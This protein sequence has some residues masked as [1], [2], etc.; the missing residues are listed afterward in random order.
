[1]LPVVLLTV[2]TVVSDEFQVTAL[3]TSSVP[4]PEKVPVAVNCFDPVPKENDT[5]PA[6]LSAMDCKP[7]SAT[8][9]LVEPLT[10]L[11]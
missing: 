4:P 10:V 2:A 8:V 3:V 9:T 5:L 11:D 1:L 7:E 6:G